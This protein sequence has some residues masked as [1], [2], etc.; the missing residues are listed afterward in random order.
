MN[1]SFV[2]L[3][4]VCEC[5]YGELMLSN[6]TATSQAVCW[7]CESGYWCRGDFEATACGPGEWSARGSKKCS[8]CSDGCT[9]PFMMVALACGSTSDR[10]C[11]P[12]PAGYACDDRGY[13]APCPI[14]SYSLAGSGKCLACKANASTGG[15]VGQTLCEWE[16]CESHEFT[17]REGL[18]R[19]CPSGFGC[20]SD[21]GAA[22]R[23]EANTFSVLGRCVGCDPN[24]VSPAGSDSVEGCVCNAGYVKLED[25]SC[26]ACS[27]GTVWKEQRCVACEAGHYCV[28]RTHQDT[29]P[30]DSYAP[31]GSAVCL[32]C[33]PFSGCSAPCTDASSCSCDPGYIRGKSG[34][35]VRCGQGTMKSGDV[36]IPCL[37]GHSCVGGNEVHRCGLGTFSLGNQSNCNACTDCHELI[38]ERCWP[39]NNSVCA[40]TTTPLAV[41][42]LFLG[43]DTISMDGDMFTM[44]ALVFASALPKA[45]VVEACGVDDECVR[46][47]QGVC[48][49]SR[50]KTRL[51]GPLY[52]LTVESRFHASKLYQNLEVLGQ[53][54][55]LHDTAAATLRKLVGPEARLA[56]RMEVKVQHEVICPDSMLWDRRLAVCYHT[57][58]PGNDTRTWAGLAVG[59][60]MLV[61]IGVYGGR[62]GLRRV[63]WL[64]V[65]AMG[66][67]I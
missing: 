51:R 44:F 64:R 29:C 25:G 47:F 43:L 20:N 15:R 13:A 54:E 4:L 22:T 28:G 32:D 49:V 39:T 56:R 18:C 67:D 31:Q 7:P 26:S 53:T 17:D 57:P 36:C 21:T 9:E 52:R 66:E 59:M 24:A 30:A 8:V 3:S 34:M 6:C 42:T 41:V 38:V 16:R 62:Q 23:C 11:A 14:D 33:R 46:C 27:P 35:C 45:R 50:M 61:G 12:C 58:T 55:F 63:G 2:A 5:S 60:A 48:P 65:P 10:V 1:A 19:A 37:P 40:P